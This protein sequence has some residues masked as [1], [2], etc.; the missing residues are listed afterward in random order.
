MDLK[1]DTRI[2]PVEIRHGRDRKPI[3]ADIF[4]SL[5]P[6]YSMRFQTP[7]EV[8]NLNEPFLIYRSPLG[9]I[10]LL[11]KT[12]IYYLRYIPDEQEIEYLKTIICPGNSISI[13]F[14]D[15]ESLNGELWEPAKPERKRISD[16]INKPVLFFTIKQDD[17]FYV[18][19]RSSIY[20]LNLGV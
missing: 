15:G 12:Y 20:I 3:D 11:N 10:H 17:Y 19:N 6:S 5:S 4:L 18:I 9:R 16:I 1:I 2:Q 7:Y 14:I 8:M 13:E